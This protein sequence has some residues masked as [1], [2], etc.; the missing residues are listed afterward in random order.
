[1]SEQMPKMFKNAF[2]RIRDTA[3][4]N[5]KTVLESYDLFKK[6]EDLEVKFSD[7]D[8]RISLDYAFKLSVYCSL[9]HVNDV[10][11]II[12][13]LATIGFTHTGM[14]AS[15]GSSVNWR[16]IR[17]NENGETIESFYLF[18]SLGS[19]SVCRFVQVGITTC[20]RYELRCDEPINGVVDP[21]EGENNEM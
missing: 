2:V 13:Y 21:S 1:M 15:S 12:R 18:S 17:R 11:P 20:P 14:D 7:L 3:K 16:F 10:K 6:I 19:S 5:S 4:K 8:T 9:N